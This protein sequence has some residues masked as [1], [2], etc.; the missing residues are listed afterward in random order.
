MKASRTIRLF[1]RSFPLQVE[2]LWLKVVSLILALLLFA[3]SRQPTS[4]VSFH[5]IPVEY[6]GLSP[7]IDIVTEPRNLIANIRL[8]GPRDTLR[9]L[10][11]S[12][13]VVVADLANKELGE[14]LIYLTAD[15]SSLPD[16][17]QVAGIE[18]PSIKLKLERTVRKIV[19]IEPQYAGQLSEGSELYGFRL[20]PNTV[21]IEGPQSLVDKT[22]MLYTESITLGGHRQNFTTTVAVEPPNSFIRVK[23]SASVNVTLEIGERRISRLFPAVPVNWPDRPAGWRLLTPI[24]SVE[25][26]GP[27]SMLQAIRDE[28]LSAEIRTTDFP[29]GTESAVPRIKLPVETD[30][31]INLRNIFPKGVKV[32][33]P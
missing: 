16:N 10:E 29:E 8:R 20:A 3:V 27:A 12:Q 2:N 32:K 30:T 7:G 11:S 6:R 24:V 28:D 4:E 26:Y 31:H 17:T 21:E 18:P 5:G 23:S 22:H 19:S 13:L 25:A 9:N 33:R 15:A 1:G 14:R